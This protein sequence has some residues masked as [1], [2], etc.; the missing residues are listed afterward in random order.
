MPNALQIVS[1]VEIVGSESLRKAVEQILE[2]AGQ[3]L[4]TLLSESG[5]RRSVYPVLEISEQ[6]FPRA[7]I[8]THF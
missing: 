1:N 8:E 6:S 4:F 5:G 7:F 3:Q 2:R